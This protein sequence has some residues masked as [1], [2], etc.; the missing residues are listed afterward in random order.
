MTHDSCHVNIILIFLSIWE[1]KAL[2]KYRCVLSKLICFFKQP[3]QKLFPPETAAAAIAVTFCF[4][5]TKELLLMI[6]SSVQIHQ[7]WRQSGRINLIMRI[8]SK[9]ITGSKKSWMTFYFE[10]TK[11]L[12]LM[13]RT[14]V[15]QIH[16]NCGSFNFDVHK[17]MYFNLNLWIRDP[18]RGQ[19]KW[20]AATRVGMSSQ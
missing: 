13:I 8:E 19:E 2:K 3:R 16:Q 7:N 10:S 15:Q 18:I 17:G 1:R 6:R 9:T 14:S 5:S 20:E 11:E 4:Q 12:L